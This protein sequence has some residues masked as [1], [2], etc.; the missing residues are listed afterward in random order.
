MLK[1]VQVYHNGQA[2]GT[3]V[4]CT[5]WLLSEDERTFTV[6][7]DHRTTGLSTQTLDRNEYTYKE[8]EQ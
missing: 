6:L 7:V 8:K 5:Q 3:P 2:F 1:V 4:W